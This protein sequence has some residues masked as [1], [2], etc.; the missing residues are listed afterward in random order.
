MAAPLGQVV[1]K[2][3]ELGEAGYKLQV[4]DEARAEKKQKKRDAEIYRTGGEKAY[5]D[6]VYKLQ[7]RYKDDVE[8]LYSELEKFGEK[9]E[10]TGDASALRMAGQISGQI[11]SVIDD[12]NTNVGLAVAK[13][14]K[15]DDVSWEGY[16]GNRDAFDEQLSNV[17][18]PSEVTG[19]RFENG[20]LLYQING[21]FVP[22]KPDRLRNW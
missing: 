19:R 17:I 18:N 10:M 9:Y 11:K 14:A 6:N 3:P 2:V 16:V 4:A 15:A 7:G 22:K 13:A 1:F 20:Q 8:L 21:E 12:Y 5:S